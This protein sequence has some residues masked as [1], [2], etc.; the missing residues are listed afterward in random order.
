MTS[1]PRGYY[2]DLGVSHTASL[3]EIKAVYR[4]LAKIYH[5]DVNKDRAAAEKFRRVTEAY[6]VIGDPARRATYDEPERSSR[7]A[8]SAAAEQESRREP[9]EPIQCS[10]C[11][12][13]TAQPRFLVFRQV[14]SFLVMTRTS[15]KP[16]IYCSDCAS[17]QAFRSSAISAAFGWWGLPWGPIY[18]VREIFRNACGGE[19]HKDIEEQLIW[20]NA[21]AFMDRGK[22]DLAGSLASQLK[23]ASDIKIAGAA[24]QLLEIL[25]ANGQKVGRLRSPWKMN[26]GAAAG[27]VLMGCA[28]PAIAYVLLVNPFGTNYRSSYQPPTKPSNTISAGTNGSTPVALAPVNL[29]KTRPAN[30]RVLD[31]NI[32]LAENG[33]RLT[34]NNG[35]SGDAIIKLRDAAIGKLVAS[36]FVKKNMT[37]SFDGIPDGGYRV[38]FAYGDAMSRDCTSFVEPSASAFDGIQNFTTETTATQIITQ[39]LSFTLYTVAGGNVR[40]TGISAADFNAN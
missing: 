2:A 9:V 40:P 35:S 3:D 20:Q 23:T 16:G 24:K 29:C 4:A 39:E 6:E 13:V 15:P 8:R 10:K 12:K 25:A 5:P 17:K 36:F 32:R 7:P 19:R 18:T 11:G 1:D 21:I 31:Q 34:I 30:G 27:Q 26:A 14:V 33:H 22:Y 38:Q 37:A 28:I